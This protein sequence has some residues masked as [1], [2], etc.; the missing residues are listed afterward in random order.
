MGSTPDSVAAASPLPDSHLHRPDHHVPVL[1]VVHQPTYHPLVEQ[2]Q[3]DAQI[4]LALAGFDLGDVG[5]LGPQKAV[6]FAVDASRLA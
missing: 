1:P 4:Q 2:I 3:H 6:S 5:D